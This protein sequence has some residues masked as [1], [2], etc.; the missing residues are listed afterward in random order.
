MYQRDDDR[1]EAV[2]K[3]IDVYREETMPLLDYYRQKGLL[4]DIPGQD[5]VDGVFQSIVGAL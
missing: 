4:S 5:T 1:P 2:Q 3:R